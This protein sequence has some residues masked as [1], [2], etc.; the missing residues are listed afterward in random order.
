MTGDNKTGAIANA[1]LQPDYTAFIR[2]NTHP[3][4]PPLVPE[5]VLHLTDDTVPLWQKAEEQLHQMNVPP[6]FW[7]FAWAGGQAL[8]RY[9]LDNAA[10]VAGRSVVDLGA[11]CGLSAIAASMAGA[12]DVL[13]ADVDPLSSHAIVLNAEANG[14]ALRATTENLLEAPPS[15]ADVLLIGDLFYER[16]L[17][18]DVITWAAKLAA[19]G[20]LVLAGDPNR[21]FFPNSRFGKIAEYSV[22]VMPELEDT[23]FKT[24]AVWQLKSA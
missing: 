5:I 10:V 3:I 11:G 13:A 2:A 20:A 14:T 23:E 15:P 7:A 8:A 6:P 12:R 24:T 9:V 4:A 22:P 1:G 16:D 19:N 17:S 21:A 18:D